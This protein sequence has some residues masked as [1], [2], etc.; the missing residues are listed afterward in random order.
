MA[1]PILSDQSPG[2]DA[3]AANAAA[4]TPSDTVDLT[5]TSRAVYVGGA[6]DLKVDMADQGTVTFSGVPAGTVLPI[7]VTRIYNTGT[8]ATNILV[9]Y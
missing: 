1:L 8:A 6:G 2:I 7:R 4:V 3:P 5:N 9:L